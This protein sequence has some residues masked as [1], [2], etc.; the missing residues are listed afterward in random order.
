MVEYPG[1]DALPEATTAPAR[2][3]QFE[4]VEHPPELVDGRLRLPSRPGLGLGN[5]VEEGVRRL[6]AGEPC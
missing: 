4:I 6:E 3:A 2:I 5:F 1:F